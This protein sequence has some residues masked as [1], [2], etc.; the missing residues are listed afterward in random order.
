VELSHEHTG[1]RWVDP[2]EYRERYFSLEG[3]EKLRAREPAIAQ[4]SAAVRVGIDEYLTWRA[5]Q[6]AAPRT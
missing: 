3:I 6:R 5:A 2:V 1:F 4:L